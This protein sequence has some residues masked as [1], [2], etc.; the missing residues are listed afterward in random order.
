MHW[1]VFIDRFDFSNTNSLCEEGHSYGC[2]VIRIKLLNL[3][4]LCTTIQVHL[5][6]R[7]RFA[8]G[9]TAN[10]HFIKLKYDIIIEMLCLCS[11]VYDNVREFSKYAHKQSKCSKTSKRCLICILLTNK[12]DKKTFEQLLFIIFMIIY[13]VSELIFNYA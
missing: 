6:H 10:L 8:L 4:A 2:S 11:Q 9:L 12:T 13:R 3:A 7:Q 1:N 5:V